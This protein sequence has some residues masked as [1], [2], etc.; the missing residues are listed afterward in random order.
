MIMVR[1]RTQKLGSEQQDCFLTSKI[2]FSSFFSCCSL[3]TTKIVGY[4]HPMKLPSPSS[5]SMMES[6]RNKAQCSIVP[7]PTVNQPGVLGAGCSVQ[8]IVKAL[9]NQHALFLLPKKVL[10]CSIGHL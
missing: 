2:V 10:V 9:K 7:V 6:K 4:L 8:C 1:V 3:R 5:S